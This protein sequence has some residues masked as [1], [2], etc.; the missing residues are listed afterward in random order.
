MFTMG[1]LLHYLSLA[2]VPSLVPMCLSH[3]LKEVSSYPLLHL[4][5]EGVEEGEKF[6]N[7]LVLHEW[8]KGEYPYFITSF[9]R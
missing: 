8:V 2:S 4:S 5:A 1:F 9:A 6:Y 7:Q 3:L